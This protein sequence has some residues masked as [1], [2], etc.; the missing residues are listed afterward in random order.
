MRA[1]LIDPSNRTVTEVDYS[2]DY[3]QIYDLIGAASRMFEIVNVPTLPDHDCYVDEEGLLYDGGNPHGF[4]MLA[5]APQPY[6]GKG[7]L[8]CCTDDGDSITATAT[9]EQVREVVTWM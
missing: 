6:A 4:F 1:I 3:T 5:L 9:L 7:L 8:L 2:G